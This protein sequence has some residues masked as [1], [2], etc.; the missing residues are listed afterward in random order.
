MPLIACEVSLTLIWSK[1]CVIT[2]KTTL[3]PSHNTDPLA[4]EMYVHFII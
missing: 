3:D 2:D 1:N 4:L